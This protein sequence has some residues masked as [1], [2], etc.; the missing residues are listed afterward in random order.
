M[1]R[2]ESDLPFDQFGHECLLLLSA[3]IVI[4]NYSPLLK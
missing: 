2:V 4:Q 3:G 1:L